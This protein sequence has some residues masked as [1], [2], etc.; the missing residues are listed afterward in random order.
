MPSLNIAVVA[1]SAG[2]FFVLA[3]NTQCR[4]R[5]N[6]RRP[7]TQDGNRYAARVTDWIAATSFFV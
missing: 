4:L 3:E 2:Q 1:E 5:G 6:H 7:T